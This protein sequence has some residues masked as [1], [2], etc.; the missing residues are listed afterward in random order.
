M[1]SH[2]NLHGSMRIHK[3]VIESTGAAELYLT[4]TPP[5]GASVEAQARRLFTA[6]RSEVVSA[7]AR[8]FSERVFATAG[9]M[10]VVDAVRREV[11]GELDDGVVPTR[12]VVSPSPFGAFAGAQVHAVR[13]PEPPVVL[14][15]C[16]L[17]HGG[18]RLLSLN[19]DSWLSVNGLSPSVDVSEAEQARQMF[20]C[21]GCFL[22]Q[23]GTSMKAVARTWL[24]LKDICSWYDDFNE[25]RT[26]FFQAQGLLDAGSGTRHLPAST[27][28]G[29]HGPNG[30][31][32]TLDLIALPGRGDCI[33]LV[34]AGGDQ[35][36]AFEYGSAFSRA[37][38]APMPGGKTVFISGTAAI[39]PTGRTEHVARV[40]AQIDDTI[41][42]VR[43]LLADLECSDKHVVTSLA[44]CKDA[45]VERTFRERWDDLGWPCIP[46]IGDVCRPDLLFEVEVTASPEADS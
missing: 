15:G 19:G 40:E 7:G 8:L 32:C 31:A 28:I 36:S 38:V 44:Y 34:E 3:R 43:S 33:E 29:L 1:D 35:H 9:A 25:A 27:G 30:A 23:A 41:A 17:A 46:M 6:L 24:W 26:S 37:A 12:V 13:S 22:H 21:T 2:T 42:H 18:A 10:R 4:A 45:E 20:F 5:E 39:D 11:Y 14:R 16:D